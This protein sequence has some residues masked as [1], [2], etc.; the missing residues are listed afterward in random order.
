MV[1]SC[2]PPINYSLCDNAAMK[3][4]YQRN[5]SDIDPGILLYNKVFSPTGDTVVASVNTT[6]YGFDQFTSRRNEMRLCLYFLGVSILA[7]KQKYELHQICDV[8]KLHLEKKHS[9]IFYSVG[10]YTSHAYSK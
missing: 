4:S 5:N 1:T 3:L 8:K 2:L 6:E 10:E 9:L 7:N